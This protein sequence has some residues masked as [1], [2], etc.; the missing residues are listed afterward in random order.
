MLPAYIDKEISLV[1]EL[2][3]CNCR[4]T[5]LKILIVSR[6]VFLGRYFKFSMILNLKSIGP[7]LVLGSRI[8]SDGEIKVDLP[9]KT[10]EGAIVR[11]EK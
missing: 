5:F 2:V 10:K 7:A 8:I 4:Y 6:T 9:P 3:K 1:V 11:L